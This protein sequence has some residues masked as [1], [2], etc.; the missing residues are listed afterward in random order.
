MKNLQYI[1][2]EGWDRDN[3]S[4]KILIAINNN[5]INSFNTENLLDTYGLEE[6][7][8]GE[9]QNYVYARSIKQMKLETSKYNYSIFKNS[10]DNYDKFIEMINQFSIGHIWHCIDDEF[11]LLHN[12]EYDGSELKE[13]ENNL[14]IV[15]DNI[16]N[17]ILLE[18]CALDG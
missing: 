6:D 11:K 18:V 14:K 7:V 10:F 3:S 16:S 1:D 8:D 15:L 4:I 2:F 9:A 13:T 12:N 17:F 5:D